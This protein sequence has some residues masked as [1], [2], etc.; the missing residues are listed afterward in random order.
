MVDGATGANYNNLPGNSNKDKQAAP[1]RQSAKPEKLP[2]SISGEVVSRKKP[3]LRR[4]AATFTGDD[5]KTVGHYVLFEVVLPAVKQLISDAASQGIERL[6]FGDASRNSRTPSRPG[7]NAYNRVSPTTA[8]NRGDT[9]GI[10]ERARATHDFNEIVLESRG[11]AEK[12][13]DD[14]IACV[15]QYDVATVSDLYDLVGITGSFQDD[16]WGWY[17]P[18]EIRVTP[19]RHGYLLNLPKTQPVE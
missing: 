10:S 9:R 13:R 17:A 8:P 19:V 7:Y 18:L 1:K 6:L 16:K 12:V 5:S 2:K 14:L 3:M 15:E 4:I 11:E